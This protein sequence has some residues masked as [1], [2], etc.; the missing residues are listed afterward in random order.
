MGRQNL[1]CF[2][3]PSDGKVCSASEWTSGSMLCARPD[4]GFSLSSHLLLTIVALT[5]RSTEFPEIGRISY[6]S[7]FHH[8]SSSGNKCFQYIVSRTESDGACS[9]LPRLR[10]SQSQRGADVAINIYSQGWGAA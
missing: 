3:E 4:Q 8:R 2:S 5:P 6:V 7:V 1:D 9:M 10:K